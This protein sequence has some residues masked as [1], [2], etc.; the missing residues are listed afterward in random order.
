M[1]DAELLEKI[2]NSYQTENDDNVVALWESYGGRE[3]NLSDI[4][5]RQLCDALAN[6]YYVKGNY[7]ESLKFINQRIEYLKSKDGEVD[8]H[9][10]NKFNLNFY[11]GMKTNILF[12]QKKYIA[13]NQ[14]VVEYINLEGKDL[15]MM[16][17]LVAAREYIFEIYVYKY[18]MSGLAVLFIN[19]LT[20]KNFNILHFQTEFSFRIFLIAGIILSLYLLLFKPHFKKI[21]FKLFGWE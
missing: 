21:T 1:N 9:Y 7:Q 8:R 18:F 3:L 4:N 14:A 2:E 15:S 11:F 10:K 19:I 6:V 5:D 20:L 12:D 17:T 13:L 16:E